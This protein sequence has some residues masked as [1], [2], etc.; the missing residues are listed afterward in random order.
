MGSLKTVQDLQPVPTERMDLF[1]PKSGH[2]DSGTSSSEAT[3]AF[4]SQDKCCCR[5]D[6]DSSDKPRPRPP[7]S[8]L[9]RICV[10]LLL[11]VFLLL[12]TRVLS[13]ELLERGLT[14]AL[15]QSIVA[16]DGVVTGVMLENF[17]FANGSRIPKRHS[18]GMSDAPPLNSTRMDSESSHDST[19]KSKKKSVAIAIGIACAAIAIISGSVLL[20]FCCCR[21]TYESWCPCVLPVMSCCL[22]GLDSFFTCFVLV[23]LC[24]TCLD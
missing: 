9:T 11:A 6:S 19:R 5:C 16:Q 15:A 2:P 20:S 8:I 18:I 14:R 12:S 7:L 22:D 24:E 17:Q 3:C 21:S 23:Q 1:S 13:T 10:V 4:C